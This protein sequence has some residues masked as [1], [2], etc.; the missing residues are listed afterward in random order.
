MAEQIGLALGYDAKA[1]VADMAASAADAE[2]HGF[3]MVF[4]SETVFSNRDSVSAL[5]AFALST[6]RVALG[7]TQ[8][9]RLRSPL[10][11]AQTAA[12]LDELSGG[13]ITLALGAYAAMHAA[14][15][16]V[17][18][19]D[20]LPTLREYVHVIRRL[21]AGETVTYHGDVVRM[22]DAA[23]GFT[24]LRAE[25]PIW[26]AANTPRGLRNAAAIGDGVLLD[27]GASPEYAANAIAI[28]R[29]GA[30]EAKRDLGRFE[31]AQLVNTS[32]D[33]DRARALDAVRWEIA[34]K[35]RY[36]RTPRWKLAVG[37]PHV[38]PADLPRLAA[39]YRDGGAA[40]LAAALPL[41]YVEGMSAAGTV[42][43][44]RSRIAA[45]REAGVTLPLLRPATPE[46][47]PRLLA[48]FAD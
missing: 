21:L 30:A 48:A 14:K 29:A 16:G 2:R 20:P 1:T 38:D 46:Q 3:G 31:I 41:G 15:N 35:F 13:R 17:A 10:L 37:E 7:A 11:M 40:A 25:I 45:Y 43:T 24:P 32:I 6:N 27:A 42:D 39:A 12:S 33:D 44:V 23:L 36:P 8:V 9:V 4:F 47:T 28:L 19:T 22:D 34:S 26:I 18:L 5:A